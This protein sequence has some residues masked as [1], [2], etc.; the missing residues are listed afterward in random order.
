MN[1]QKLMTLIIKNLYNIKYM[2]ST[3]IIE[4]IKVLSLLLDNNDKEIAQLATTKLK[5]LINLL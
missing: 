4:A 5:E 1:I 3:E 2:S